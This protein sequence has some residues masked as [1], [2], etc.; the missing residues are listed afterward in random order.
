MAKFNPIDVF[1]EWFRRYPG[2]TNPFDLNTAEKYEFMMN[3]IERVGL[4]NTRYAAELLACRKDTANHPAPEWTKYEYWAEKY[5]VT[6]DRPGPLAEPIVC[7]SEVGYELYRDWFT[8]HPRIKSPTDID[9]RIKYEFLKEIGMEKAV[10]M[11]K[12]RKQKN[13]EKKY[14]AW[15]KPEY[16]LQKKKEESEALING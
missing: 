4:D 16:W 6:A 3:F 13:S 5:P 9:M 2:V 12:C 1:E 10:I 8:R 14:H 11:H 7:D 15:T